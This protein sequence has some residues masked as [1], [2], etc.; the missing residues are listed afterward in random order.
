M[1][2]WMDGLSRQCV[3]VCEEEREERERERAVKDEFSPLFMYQ[4]DTMHDT[5]TS[6]HTYLQ[7]FQTS[8]NTYIAFKNY[9]NTAN[10]EFQTQLL[11]TQHSY[12]I[13]PTSTQLC[14]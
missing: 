11:S 9:A 14:P 1:D 6:L 8:T 5:R 10:I 3:L 12:R 7:N 13:I 2:G 4:L